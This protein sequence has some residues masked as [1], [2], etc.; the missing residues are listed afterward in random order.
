MKFYKLFQR[1]VTADFGTSAL[2]A[3]DYGEID[4]RLVTEPVSW[5]RLVF[6]NVLV[7]ASLF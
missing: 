2:P 7:A 4:V 1:G 3:Y 6:R 5:F